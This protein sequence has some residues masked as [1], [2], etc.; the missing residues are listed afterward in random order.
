M[1][2]FKISNLYQCLMCPYCKNEAVEP[3]K[4]TIYCLN[5]SVIFCEKSK[6][7]LT[8]AM[9]IPIQKPEDAGLVVVDFYCDS[10]ESTYNMH[11]KSY[12][13]FTRCEWERERDK[14]G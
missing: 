8:P 11:L 5:G 7:K 3:V 6:R 2:N 9:D 10:C 13:G 1:K 12:F 4:M 14:I